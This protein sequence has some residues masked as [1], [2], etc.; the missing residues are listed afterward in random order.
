MNAQLWPLILFPFH[1]SS[2]PSTLFG[3]AMRAWARRKTNKAL[4][5]DKARRAGE[6]AEQ[7][8]ADALCSFYCGE[9]H[10]PSPNPLAAVRSGSRAV[11]IKT[12]KALAT[13]KARRAGE[14][15]EQARA[16]ALCSFYRGEAHA[17]S[18]SPLAAV[19]SGSRAVLIKTNAKHWRQTKLGE[20]AKSQSKHVQMHY[21]VSIIA[22]KHM[23][24][25]RVRSLLSEAVR[26]LAHR[27]RARWFAISSLFAMSCKVWYFR[28][29]TSSI[30]AMGQ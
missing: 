13:D 15:A 30:F 2:K 22:A 8:L 19:R 11:L 24:L 29:A 21:V 4:A 25:R 7:A 14:I 26:G 9:A 3:I 20:R 10:A 1:I 17:P 23:L 5:T 12:N 18:P 16:D 6:I 27:C 28:R